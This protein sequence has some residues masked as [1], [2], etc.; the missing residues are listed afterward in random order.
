MF[1]WLL[2]VLV[3]APGI[4]TRH[5]WTLGWAWGIYLPD[6]GSNVGPLPFEHGVLATWPPGKMRLFS[7][8]L[9]Y[10]ASPVAQTVKHLPATRENWVQPL[11]WEDPLEK[12]VGEHFSVLAWRI[13]WTE[14]PGGYSLTLQKQKLLVHTCKHRAEESPSP[15][16]RKIHFSPVCKFISA[17]LIYKSIVPWILLWS[18][19]KTLLVLLPM[20]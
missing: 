16:C 4:F 18:S 11:S 8:R 10:V 2:W 20:S 14:E 1:V 5:I 7:T 15:H 3:A 12:G 9:F 6:Q 17:F 13:P 19:C